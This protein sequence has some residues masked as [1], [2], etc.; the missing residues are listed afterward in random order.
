M[1]NLFQDKINQKKSMKKPKADGELSRLQRLL[2]KEIKRKFSSGLKLYIID[3]GACGA[4]ELEFQA[5]FNPLYDVKSLGVEVVYDIKEADILLLIGL[6]TENMYPI[7]LDAYKN[8]KEPK[9]VISIGDCI[10]SNAPFKNTFAIKGQANIHFLVER[11]IT[12]CP[13][14]PKAL[15]RGLLKHLQ[16]GYSK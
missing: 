1:Y 13:P 12:G 2:K 8:L 16:L 9:Q 15:L 14:N 7:C 3:T 5:L 10:M 4:C 11:H 6:L